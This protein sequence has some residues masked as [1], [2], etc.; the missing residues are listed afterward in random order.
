MV[1]ERNGISEGFARACRSDGDDVAVVGEE[2]RYGAALNGGGCCDVHAEKR[3]LERG[4]LDKGREGVFRRDGERFCMG[5]L[6]CGGRGI[7]IVEKVEFA[8]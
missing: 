5:V 1:H 4:V 6:G 7:V 8:G 3:G 2:V